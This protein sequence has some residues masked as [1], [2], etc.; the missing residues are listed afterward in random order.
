[1]WR[2]LLH[3]CVVSCQF[4]LLWSDDCLLGGYVYSYMLLVMAV[5]PALLIWVLGLL[6]EIL[7]LLNC[8]DYCLWDCTC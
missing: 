7:C 5:I 1:M 2:L 8:F 4:G 6:L 3:A